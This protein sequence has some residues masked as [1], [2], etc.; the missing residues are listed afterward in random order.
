MM[1]TNNSQAPLLTAIILASCSLSLGVTASEKQSDYKGSASITQGLAATVEANLFECKNGRSRVAGVGEIIDSEGKVWTV[2]AENQFGSA[3]K[4]VDLYE[5]CANITPKS[6]AE[7]DENLVPVVVIDA[8]GQEVT[9]YIFADNYFELYVNGQ[10]VAVD[11]VP[12][13][14]FNSSIVKFKVNKPYT[15]AVKVI[16][17]EENLGLGTEN[18]RGKAFHPGDGGFIASFSDG[19]VTNSDWQA[20]TFY[21]SPIYDLACLSEVEGQR[22]S[23]NCTTDGTDSGENAYAAHWEVPSNWMEPEF[24]SNSWPQATQYSENEIGVNNKK[25]YMNFIE[26]FS[27]AGASFIWSTNVVLDNEV[28]LR[29][30]VR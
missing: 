3:T 20:Q 29:Y 6:I 23:T 26:K 14:P 2:P 28:L 11:S 17:W 13:T 24:D 5:E 27:G 15:I 30:V 10:L 8:D 19:T 16:D 12:F 18:N 25:S 22:L 21:T 4:A 9:G 7:V 1:I